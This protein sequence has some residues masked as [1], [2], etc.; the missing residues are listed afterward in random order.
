MASLESGAAEEAGATTSAATRNT[1]LVVFAIALH[2]IPEG[3]AVAVA[4]FNAGE[5]PGMECTLH[6]ES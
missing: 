2:N 3:I 4:L 1:A 5:F 6:S